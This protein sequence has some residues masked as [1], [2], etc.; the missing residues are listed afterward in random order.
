MLAGLK[1]LEKVAL[2][3]NAQY[4]DWECNDEKMSLTKTERRSICTAS[5]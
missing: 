4:M 1:E 2:E 5:R 3:N